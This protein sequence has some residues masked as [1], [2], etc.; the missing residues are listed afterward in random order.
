VSRLKQCGKKQRGQRVTIGLSLGLFAVWL[1]GIR[2]KC[3]LGY[4]GKIH[5]RFSAGSFCRG[6][7]GCRLNLLYYQWVHASPPL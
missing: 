7:P 3:G 2:F 6:R 1:F 5:N 4:A